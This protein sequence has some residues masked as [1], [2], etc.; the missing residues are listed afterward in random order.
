MLHQAVETA[1]TLEVS[2]SATT[3]SGRHLDVMRIYG[4]V[5][6]LNSPSQTG[7]QRVPISANLRCTKP[8]IFCFHTEVLVVTLGQEGLLDKLV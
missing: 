2:G 8:A 7:Q 3:T 6:G 5:Q 4:K 1:D